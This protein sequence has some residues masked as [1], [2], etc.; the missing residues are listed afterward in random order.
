MPRTQ[1]VDALIAE[2]ED[3]IA[4]PVESPPMSQ[5]AKVTGG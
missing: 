5:N 2:L 1:N 3:A 4:A